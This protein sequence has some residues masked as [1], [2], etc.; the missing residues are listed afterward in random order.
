MR[1]QVG[2]ERRIDAHPWVDAGKHF[3]L[4][5]GRMEMAGSEGDEADGR[6]GRATGLGEGDRIWSRRMATA[7]KETRRQGER[8]ME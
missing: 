7:D 8:E 5:Q 3:F 4:N 6:H 1:H 2:V